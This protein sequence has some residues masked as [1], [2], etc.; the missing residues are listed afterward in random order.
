MGRINLGRVIIGGLVAGLIVNIF[1]YVLNGVMLSDQWAELMRGIGKPPLGTNEIIAFNVFGFI[2]G[3]VA[4][5]TYAAIRPRFGA[6]PM[7]AVYA[8]LLTWITVYVL[9][10]AMPA[11]MGIF[12]ISMTLILVGVGLI[13]IVIAT[14]VGAFLYKEE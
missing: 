10:D 2:S 14:L 3:I 9:A 11:I 7:T 6:G 5:W 8:A 1:E 13:E 4:V 12:P